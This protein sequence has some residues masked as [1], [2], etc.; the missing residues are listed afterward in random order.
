MMQMGYNVSMMNDI[1]S[2]CFLMKITLILSTASGY[3]RA[4]QQCHTL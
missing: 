3:L 2:L 4:S 1:Q